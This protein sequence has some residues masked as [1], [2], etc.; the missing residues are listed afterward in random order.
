MHK[1]LETL[2]RGLTNGHTLVHL[3]KALHALGEWC[4]QDDLVEPL[5]KDGAI[6]SVV[7]LLHINSVTCDTGCEELKTQAC[8]ILGLLAVRPDIQDRIARSGALTPLIDLLRTN[9]R[10]GTTNLHTERRDVSRRAADAL[11]NL[12]LENTRI[13]QQIREQQGIPAL[14]SLL[15]TRDMK[16]QRATAGA[17]RTLA[18]QNEENKLEMVKCGALPKLVKLLRSEDVSVHYE[19]VGVIGNLVHSSANIK[20]LVLAEGALQPIIG[21][22]NSPC[23]ETKR[24][25][26]LLLGQFAATQETD[27]RVRIAQRGAIPSL[28]AMLSIDDMSAKEMAAFA[29][30]RLAQ[31]SDNQ[32]IVQCGGLKPLLDLLASNVANMQHMAAFALYSLADNEDNVPDLLRAGVLERL[33]AYVHTVMLQSSKDCVNKTIARMKEKLRQPRVMAATA[34]MLCCTPSRA[35]QC[36]LAAALAHLAPDE[37]LM[38]LF[39]RDGALDVLTAAASSSAA[40]TGGKKAAVGALLQLWRRVEDLSSVSPPAPPCSVGGAGERRT[41]Y[42]GEA[43]VNSAA[44]SDVCFLVEG[45]PLHAHRIVLVAASDAFRAMFGGAYREAGASPVHIPNIRYRVFE[46]M[47]RYIYTGHLQPDRDTALELLQASDQYLLDGLKRV[48]EAKIAETL[49]PQTLPDACQLS[50]RHSAPRLAAGCALFALRQHEEVQAHV[51]ARTFA[52]LLSR[53]MP[54]FTGLLREGLSNLPGQAAVDV[55]MEECDATGS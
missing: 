26:A 48:C 39:L 8:F 23:N 1:C 19:A 12:A 3:L 43:F 49:S 47:L 38:G 2:R 18:F 14:V 34:Y 32:G 35:V 25:A 6:E 45:R 30:G 40:L 31:C 55:K 37:E 36:T 27:W 52:Q 21:L 16:L 44:L 29:L 51:G 28:I 11:S 4:Q 10:K 22:L 41:V 46:S 42:L 33:T 24:E 15:D 53:I 50:E 20:R 5:V 54:A 7:P 17:L 13:Q 9:S